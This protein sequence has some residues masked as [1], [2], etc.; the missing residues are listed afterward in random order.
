MNWTELL[1]GGVEES[2]KATE[3]LLNMVKDSELDWKPAAGQ[4]W[5]TMGQLLMHITSSCGACCKGFVTGDWGF[6]EDVDPGSSPSK[7]ML[8]AAEEMPAVKSVEEARKLL[9]EDKKLALDMIQ[10][11]GEKDLDARM[12]KA[13][14][15]QASSQLGCQLLSMIGHLTLHKSQLFYY[16]KLQGKPVNTMTL[17]GM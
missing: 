3:G 16:L 17:F 7:S 15:D 10:R 4:N 2:Y 1:R 12:V 8:P 13:P 9:A 14:W 5:M 6:P 11:S